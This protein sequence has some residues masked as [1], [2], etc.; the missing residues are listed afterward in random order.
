MTITCNGMGDDETRAIK[1]W[2][3]MKTMAI[4]KWAK[5]KRGQYFSCTCTITG[6]IVCI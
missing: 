3:I 5:I 1:K 2:A 4:T 6:L